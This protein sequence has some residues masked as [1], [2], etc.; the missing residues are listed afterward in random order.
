MFQRSCFGVEACPLR[1]LAGM[2][3]GHGRKSWAQV[4]GAGHGRRSWAQVM[5]AANSLD[6]TWRV[7][8][9]QSSHDFSSGVAR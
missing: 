9:Q 3:A 1:A 7:G 8:A 5:D 4:M 6:F 2:G